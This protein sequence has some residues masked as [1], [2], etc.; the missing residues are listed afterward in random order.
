MKLDIEVVAAQRS[1]IF[2]WCGSAQG[3]D[4]GRAVSVRK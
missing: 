1:F 3:L 4:Q 2:L